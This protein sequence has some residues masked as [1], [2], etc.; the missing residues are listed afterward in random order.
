MR[1]RIVSTLAMLSVLTLAGYVVAQATKPS[2]STLM[3]SIRAVDGVEPSMK[4]GTGGLFWAYT[5][6]ADSKV[7]AKLRRELTTKGWKSNRDGRKEV[8]K[9]SFGEFIKTKGYATISSPIDGKVRI[10][11]S[12]G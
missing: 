7:P 8:F 1:N 4:C 11:I 5:L 2:P 6:A 10:S 3:R 9:H 12:F